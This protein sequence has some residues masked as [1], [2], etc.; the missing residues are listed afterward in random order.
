MLALHWS[1]SKKIPTGSDLGSVSWFVE[2]L[3]NGSCAYTR[4]IYILCRK[5]VSIDGMCRIKGYVD[6]LNVWL[7]SDPVNI[8]AH[9]YKCLCCAPTH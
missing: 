2:L 9:P 7:R 5:I 6:S 4:F 8:L 3:Y 1:Q